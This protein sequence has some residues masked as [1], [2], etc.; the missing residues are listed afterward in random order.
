LYSQPDVPIQA[1]ALLL[2]ANSSVPWWLR[3]IYQ[4]D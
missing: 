2:I 1:R 3:E 4:T